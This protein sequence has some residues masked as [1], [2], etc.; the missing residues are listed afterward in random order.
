[1]VWIPPGWWHEVETKAG[2]PVSH[3]IENLPSQL[4]V[5]WVSWAWPKSAKKQAVS[6]WLAG[7]VVEKQGPQHMQNGNVPVRIRQA[8]YEA[9]MAEDVE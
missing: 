5:S 2:Q 4:C 7:W 1:M 9:I 8:V 6:Q 3:S